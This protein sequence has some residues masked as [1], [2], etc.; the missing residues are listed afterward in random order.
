MPGLETEASRA[1]DNRSLIILNDPL[2]AESKRMD[3]WKP[4]LPAGMP[5]EL[6]SRLNPAARGVVQ[7][8]GMLL[9]QSLVFRH[10][11]PG[12]LLTGVPLTIGGDPWWMSN[13]PR[14]SRFF[15]QDCPMVGVR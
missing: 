6:I 3:D 9:I 14:S 12:S 10:M 4:F 13:R 5:V 2:F 1:K 15:G 7:L 11:G 8:R